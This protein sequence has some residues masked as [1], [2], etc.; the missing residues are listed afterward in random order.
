MRNNR[1]KFLSLL[2][3]TAFFIFALVLILLPEADRSIWPLLAV[4]G[5]IL[6]VFW[7][8]YLIGRSREKKGPESQVDTQP[9]SREDAI[10]EAQ[11]N[12]EEIPTSEPQDGTGTDT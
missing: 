7:I 12:A 5:I 3:S 9:E 4:F 2:L 8:F 1:S 10:T 6:V 11:V